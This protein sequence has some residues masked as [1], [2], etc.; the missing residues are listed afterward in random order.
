MEYIKKAA[1]SFEE[2]SEQ[3]R[4]VVKGLLADIELRGE[5]AVTEM[6]RKFDGWE[7]E[8]ILSAE[9]K[10]ELIAQVP[11]HVKADIR[12]AHEQVAGF[13][14]AQ[15]DSIREFEV[16]SISGVRLGQKVIPMTVAGCYIP[17]GRFA[18]AC[19]AIMS[20]AT[21]R[22]AGVK[23]IIGCSPPP[24]CQHRPGRGLCHGYF[25]LRHH[26]ADGRGTGHRHHGLRPV[27]RHPG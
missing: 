7:G 1:L 17:G 19:S 25:R 8:F 27:H 11:E 9:R 10:A 5:A 20:I 24:R 22:A 16:V 15:R 14:R 18:H 13:A 26:F 6:A 23:T 21:A 4:N 12:F 2:A 3:K